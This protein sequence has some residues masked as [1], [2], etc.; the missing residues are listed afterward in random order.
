MGVNEYETIY[1]TGSSSEMLYAL[2]VG[3]WALEKF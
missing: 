1:K 2:I 3:Y